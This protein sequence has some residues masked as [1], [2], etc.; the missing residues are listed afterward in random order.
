LQWPER[1]VG[2]PGPA[3]LQREGVGGPHGTP[4]K[5]ILAFGTPIELEDRKQRKKEQ[6][7][8]DPLE[9]LGRAL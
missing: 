6:Y 8:T 2:W 1:M 9:P 5:S 3:L 7:Q 4:Q